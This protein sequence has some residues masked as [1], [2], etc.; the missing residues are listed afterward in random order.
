MKRHFILFLLTVMPVIYIAAQGTIRGNV[1][2]VLL[3]GGQETVAPLVGAEVYVT[4]GGSMIKTTTN[5]HGDYT[6]KP[7]EPGIYN[8]TINSILI[9]TLV[10]TNIQVSGTGVTFVEDKKVPLG[11]SLDRVVISSS[12]SLRNASPSKGELK[13][14]DLDNLPDPNINKAIE[15]MGGTWVSDNGRQISFRGARIGDALYIIDGVRQRSTEVSLPNR[16]IA[17]INAWHGGVPAEYGDFMGG[18][19]VI[20][21]MSYFDWENQQEVKRLIKKKEKE[22]EEFQD[23]FND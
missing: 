17:T 7:L 8:V 15:L 1:T 21:T 14:A 6:I 16:S 11:R 23:R 2:T 9:D 19:V 12:T 3:Q 20:E 5:N 10:V 18:V 4:Y 22:L 13:G